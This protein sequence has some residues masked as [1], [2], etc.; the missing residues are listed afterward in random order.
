[1]ARP[2]ICTAC[3]MAGAPRTVTR[4][5]LLIEIVLWLCMLLPGLLYSIWRLTT[6]HKACRHCGS[7]VIVPQDS[8]RG[9]SLLAELGAGS[10][11]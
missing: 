1:M 2:M 5:S 7:T 3:G 11:R 4:G 6:K 9:R 10:A 8:P